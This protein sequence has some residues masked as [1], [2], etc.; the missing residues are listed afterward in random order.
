MINLGLIGYPLQ[1]S[2]SPLIHTAALEYCNLPGN[3]SLF[4]VL[5]ND[6]HRLKDLLNQVRSGETTGL[7]VTIPFKQTVIPLLDDLTPTAKAIGAVNTISKQNGKLIGENTDSAGF[8]AD[9][10][11]F[12][13]KVKWERKEKKNA[14]VLGGG[15]SARAISYALVNDGWIVTLAIR[16]PENA[17]D[18]LAQF[19]DYESQ[20][21]SIK[22]QNNAIRSLLP[23]LQLIVNATPVGMSPKIE[24]SPW[25]ADL[26]FPQKAVIY[27]LVYHPHDTK[28]ILAA[29]AAGLPAI[30]GLGMLVEQAALAFELWTGYDVPR[31]HLFTAVEET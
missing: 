25:S 18:F 10:Q 30:T 7:N 19:S 31:E 26:S 1:N 20:I 8:L 6:L 29:R 16:R 11:K 23:H 9:L 17:K 12:L 27:D 14:L 15:G 13:T 3:Y 22:Y 5:P 28:F 4:P 2:F 24:N 21:S